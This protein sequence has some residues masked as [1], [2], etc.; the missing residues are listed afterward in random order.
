MCV[1]PTFLNHVFE[2]YQ[3][4][5][6]HCRQII[7]ERISNLKFYILYYLSNLTKSFLCDAALSNNEYFLFLYC[8]NFRTVGNF[9]IFQS[10]TNVLA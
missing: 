10:T 2:M 7:V 1:H 3:D 5:F 6:S 8:L 4:I 9:F